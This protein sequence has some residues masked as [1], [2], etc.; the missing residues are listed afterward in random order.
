[1]V[2]SVLSGLLVG[3][4]FEVHV[5]AVIY[6]PVIV[7]LFS[8]KEGWRFYRQRVF[9]GF[10]AGSIGTLAWYLL[11]H[12]VQFPEAY[13]GMGAARWRE[14]TI[15]HCFPGRPLVNYFTARLS[16]ISLT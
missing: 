10:V 8:Q 1:M 9:W 4:A 6:G 12:V 15:H 11:A 3:L 16:E 14:H 13:F 2:L 7:A 5:N